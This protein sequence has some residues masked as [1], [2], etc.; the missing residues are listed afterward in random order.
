[1]RYPTWK[2]ILIV[3]VLCISTIYSLPNLYPDEPAIQISGANAGIKADQAVLTAPD[4]RPHKEPN[5]AG[6]ED[7]TTARHDRQTT[8]RQSKQL[9]RLT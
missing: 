4:S 5:T 3:L 8:D 2:Y 6:Q 1:M 9:P 7:R